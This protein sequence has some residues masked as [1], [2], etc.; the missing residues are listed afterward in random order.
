MLKN[1]GS[2]NVAQGVVEDNSKIVDTHE[3]FI[4]ITNLAEQEETNEEQIIAMQTER[5]L[6]TS[7]ISFGLGGFNPFN[8]ARLNLLYTVIYYPHTNF[9][10]SWIINGKVCDVCV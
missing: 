2:R 4:I 10:L 5:W 3:H 7:L 9:S 1:H 6:V 8:E